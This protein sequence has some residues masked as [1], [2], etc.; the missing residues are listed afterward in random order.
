MRGLQKAGRGESEWHERSCQLE[1]N[2][3]Y[4]A[5]LSYR[6]GTGRFR[7][8]VTLCAHFN[9]R[10][11]AVALC[12]V[13]PVLVYL[14]WCVFP[15]PIYYVSSAFLSMHSYQSHL[16][17][18]VAISADRDQTHPFNSIYPTDRSW[19]IFFPYGLFILMLLCWFWNPIGTWFSKSHRMFFDKLKKKLTNI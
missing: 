14:M 11:A 12:L 15:E 5:F 6:G 17:M 1:R 2:Q 13:F 9:I 18:P 16:I 8:W 10:A 4:D 19:F 3:E 7:L